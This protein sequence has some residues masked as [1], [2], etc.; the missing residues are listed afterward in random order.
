[1]RIVIYLVNKT[2]DL[3]LEDSLSDNVEGLLQRV[4][5]EPGYR[6]VFATKAMWSDHQR[7]AVN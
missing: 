4:R 1:M 2:E 7:I 6:G 3:D 5:K